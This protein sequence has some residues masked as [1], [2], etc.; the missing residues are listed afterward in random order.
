MSFSSWQIEEIERAV[1]EADRGE[2]VSD[3]EVDLMLTRWR[4]VAQTSKEK[5]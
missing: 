1:S 4:K 3:E 5:G 2:F